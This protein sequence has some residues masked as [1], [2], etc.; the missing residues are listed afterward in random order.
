V[1]VDR[2]LVTRP[3]RVLVTGAGGFVG[4]NLVRRLLGD[5]HRVT[6]VLGPG[7]DRW[8]LTGLEG[9]A[10]LVEVDLRNEDALRR[11]VRQAAPEWTFHLA[12]HGAYSW[13]R[14]ARRI[15]DTNLMATIALVEAC[16]EAGCDAFVHAGSSSEYG[17][18]DHAPSEEELAEP[19]SRYAVAKAA[20]TLCCRY[21]AQH[22]QFPAVTLRLYSVFGPY[23][24]P[25]RLVPAVVMHARRNE[26][27]P[28][29][30]PEVAHDFVWVDDVV[31]ALLLAAEA[32]RSCGG[33]VYNV[34]TGV[35]T[36]LAQF[37][38]IARRV[39]HVDAEPTWGSMT[40]RAWDATS[41]VA[42]NRRIQAE[43]GWQPRTDL[44]EGLRRTA[45]WLL[46]RDGHWQGELVAP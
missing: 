32:A 6:G 36:S 43:L 5:G 19:N 2:T 28:L 22:E 4:A 46:A 18:K 45:A 1:T 34:G 21:V 10:Q 27:P 16:R 9:Q 15:L 25:R 31:E 41:W 26:L 8:R 24:D 13:Q 30:A 12:A 38:D 14:D 40:G 20:A 33:S 29:V 44:A 11:L 3:R 23:E 35:E 7:G 37:V 39:L 17:F 42:D